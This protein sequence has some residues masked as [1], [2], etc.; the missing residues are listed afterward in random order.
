MPAS[1]QM[2]GKR[3][4]SA[5]FF[6]VFIKSFVRSLPCE[7]ELSDTRERSFRRD[8]VVRAFGIIV[9]IIVVID[10]IFKD[11]LRFFR[12]VFIGRSCELA[13]VFDA[14]VAQSRIVF[15]VDRGAFFNVWASDIPSSAL[16]RGP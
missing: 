10:F 9:D 3:I 6:D 1:I 11:Q 4:E 12:D 8:I 5:G 16:R 15:D 14:L 7:R 13:Q 2:I